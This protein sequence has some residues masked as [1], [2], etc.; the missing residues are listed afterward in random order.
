MNRTAEI[1]RQ[2]VPMRQAAEHY[3]FSVDRAGFIRCP[4]HSGDHQASLKIYPG[5][6]GFCCF[7]CGAKGSV[8][9]FVMRLFE[10]SFSDACAHLNEEFHLNLQIGRRPTYRERKAGRDAVI[11][12]HAKEKSRMEKARQ[13][14]TADWQAFDKWCVADQIILQYSPADSGGRILP[15]YASALREFPQLSFELTLAEIARR[16]FEQTSRNSGVG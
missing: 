7:G 8:I 10:C 11:A 6:G 16:N 2:E 13:L 1:I 15:L 5:Q 3:G 4:F 12:A 14:E 9:D